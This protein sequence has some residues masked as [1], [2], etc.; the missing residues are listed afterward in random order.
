VAVAGVDEHP[1]RG[2]RGLPAAT[3]AAALSISA[4]AA[5]A[6]GA[7]ARGP[8]RPERQDLGHFTATQEG[9]QRA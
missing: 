2:I 3:R 5:A 8:T 6:G 9:D 4:A 1:E 7:A